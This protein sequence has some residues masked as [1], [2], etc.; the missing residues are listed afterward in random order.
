MSCWR[1]STSHFTPEETPRKLAK[2]KYY[3]AIKDLHAWAQK[4][5]EIPGYLTQ[6]QALDSEYRL[7]LWNGAV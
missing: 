6:M 1:Q 4:R 2:V 7:S 3:E 5:K